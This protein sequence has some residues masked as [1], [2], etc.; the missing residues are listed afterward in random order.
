VE[1]FS[2]AIS[3]EIS[4]LEL[5]LLYGSIGMPCQ[6]LGVILRIHSIAQQDI[7]VVE[8]SEIGHT[9]VEGS[10]VS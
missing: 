3:S 9:I 4:R 6:A 10:S 7:K 1:E 5:L 2:N 8:K